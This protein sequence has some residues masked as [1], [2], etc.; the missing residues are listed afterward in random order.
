MS[1]RNYFLSVLI[2]VFL[3]IIVLSQNETDKPVFV[4]EEG[5]DGKD[6]IWW[7]T[8]PTLIKG[9]LD[10]AG[11]GPDDYVV[12]LGSG[13][14][15]IVIEAAKRGAT[16][17]G[18]EYN[19]DLVKLSEFRAKEEGVADKATFLNMDLFEYDLSGATVITM[20]LLSD[21]N[22]RLRPSLLKL[23]PG[24]RIVSNT[25]DLGDWEADEN[26]TVTTPY[27]YPDGSFRHNVTNRGYFWIV[28]AN[29]A[30]SWNLDGGRLKLEQSYQKVEGSW[31]TSGKS[32]PVT[33]GRMTGN[34]ISF[35]IGD[36]GYTGTLENGSLQ[37]TLK[38]SGETR[39][40]EA[41]RIED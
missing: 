24:T 35:T 2:L 18:I 27:H 16:A 38:V 11:V 15:R 6:V 1:I 37:G 39:S 12:D 21:L 29:V 19:P 30:G 34:K 17:V 28:P 3:P 22:L 26:I 9:M 10:I 20:Y 40:W 31:Q 7:P 25:F 32:I 13:D 8:P 36:T 4:P 41:V 33:Y 5:I 23:K 14:G